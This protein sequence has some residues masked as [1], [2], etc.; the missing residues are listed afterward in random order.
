M[1]PENVIEGLYDHWFKARPGTVCVYAGPSELHLRHYRDL[2][3]D[4]CCADF[5]LEDDTTRWAWIPL[6][7]KLERFRARAR[8]ERYVKNL[9]GRTS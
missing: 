2:H 5:D 6:R 4:R 3:S 9:L 7:L 1:N 8:A